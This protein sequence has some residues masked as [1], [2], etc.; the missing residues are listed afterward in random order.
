MQYKEDIRQPKSHVPDAQH[1]I[2]L[3]IIVILL[4][5]PLTVAS[6]LVAVIAIFKGNYGV[7]NEF[8]HTTSKLLGFMVA[9]LIT[10]YLGAHW[11]VV[12]R[13]YRDI[14][15]NIFGLRH[16]ITLYGLE[17]I[18]IAVFVLALHFNLYNLPTYMIPVIL[19]CIVGYLIY[20]RRYL[21]AGKT[22]R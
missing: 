1:R 10:L 7:A 4:L 9:V 21:L 12:V 19:F 2:T 18:N 8:T 6:Y 20:L 3:L 14:T 5:S 17:V 15:R 22:L 16:F 11:Y 13:Y